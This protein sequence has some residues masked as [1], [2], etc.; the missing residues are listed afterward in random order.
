MM[1]YTKQTLKIMKIMEI[2]EVYTEKFGEN[3]PIME[4]AELIKHFLKKQ[5]ESEP[6]VPSKPSGRVKVEYKFT[7]I[8]IDIEL[9]DFDS[10]NISPPKSDVITVDMINDMINRNENN[11][12]DNI[13]NSLIDIYKAKEEKYKKLQIQKQKAIDSDAAEI[14]KYRRQGIYDTDKLFPLYKINIGLMIKLKDLQEKARNAK[15]GLQASKLN[16]KEKIKRSI[17]EAI[18]DQENG[19]VSITG[20]NRKDIREYLCKQIYI[21]SKGSQ[22]FMDAFLNMVFTGPAGVGK[23]KLANSVGFVYSKL[24]V[25]LNNEVVVVSPKDMIGEYVGQTAGKTAGVLM[26]GLES[27]LFIDEAYQIMP[28]D[29]GKLISN[30]KSFGPEAITEI[31]NFLDK[32]MGLSIMVVAGYEREME[33]CFFAANEG[34]YRR[35]P[36]RLD[37]PSYTDSDLANIMLNVVNS[38]LGKNM[39]KTES[40][41]YV[42][43]LISKLRSIDEDIFKNQAGDMINLASNF[44]NSYY[45]SLNIVW[46]SYGNDVLIINGAFNQFLKNKGYVMKIN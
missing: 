11:I 9:Y 28:C 2:K 32:Y 35:F 36:N 7:D 25:L 17:L 39:F 19:I 3:P 18:N 46:G 33:G 6:S 26:K 30:T 38:K 40:A 16:A 12:L 5:E 8:P 31:V 1:K 29:N 4:K 14:N 10:G 22:T 20:E 15:I 27:I 21:L 44:M 45:G 41:N 43:S 13:V 42:F 24:G 34:L 37:L 23:T